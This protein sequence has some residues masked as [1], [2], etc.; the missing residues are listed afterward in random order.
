MDRV[1]RKCARPRASAGTRTISARSGRGW[2]GGCPRLLSTVLSLVQ[3][4]ALPLGHRASAPGRGSLRPHLP[5]GGKCSKRRTRPIQNASFASHP[6]LRSCRLRS[7]SIPQRI[8]A[9]HHKHTTQTTLISSRRCLKTV[10][11]FRLHPPSSPSPLGM[12][13]YM[14]SQNFVT[15]T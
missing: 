10:D 5:H 9:K 15:Y 2:S 4:R 6:G 12:L 13:K 8:Q 7:G 11:R 14:M 1:H 3:P